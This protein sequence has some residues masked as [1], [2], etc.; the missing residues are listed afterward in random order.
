MKLPG[1]GLQV[2]SRVNEENF[3]VKFAPAF[4]IPRAYL[5]YHL[6]ITRNAKKLYLRHD[7]KKTGFPRRTPTPRNLLFFI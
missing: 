3:L 1:F 7:L 2:R 5:L 6:S 4:A